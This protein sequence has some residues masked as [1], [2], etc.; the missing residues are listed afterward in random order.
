M[1]KVE[2]NISKM[3]LILDQ[4][5]VDVIL[6]S[7]LG[8]LSLKIE[9]NSMFIAHI[10]KGKGEKGNNCMAGNTS[11]FID[12]DQKDEDPFQYQIDMQSKMD[13]V[14]KD[15]VEEVM[16]ADKEHYTKMDNAKSAVYRKTRTNDVAEQMKQSNALEDTITSKEFL[17]EKLNFYQD[18]SIMYDKLLK[19][20]REKKF[21]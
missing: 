8:Y 4:Q 19:I 6:A 7:V 18:D 11:I 10:L 13:K 12:A 16:K 5:E 21:I 17:F 20:G 3:I 14:T 1:G 15:F 2:E 9:D